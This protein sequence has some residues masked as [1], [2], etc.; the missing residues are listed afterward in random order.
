MATHSYKLMYFDGM[1]RAEFIR[2]VFAA[3]EV[4]FEDVRFTHQEWPKYK[5]LAPF[6]QAPYLEV[7]SKS[8]GQ[9]VA[10]ATY[11]AREFGLHGKNN[12]E[13]L[14]VDQVLGLIQDLIQFGIKIYHEKE[15]GKR[16]ELIQGF[17]DVHQPQF[18]GYFE[19]LLSDNGTGYLV[20]NDLSLADIAVFDVVTGWLGTYMGPIDDFPLVKALVDKVWERDGIKS[21]MAA[22]PDREG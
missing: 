4:P 5:K 16:D 7:A 2:L 11:L 10:I 20:G 21:Y 12:L 19:K 14:A 9:S 22:R 6:G 13:G 17:K 18:L 15:K 1:G 8:Y 3:A